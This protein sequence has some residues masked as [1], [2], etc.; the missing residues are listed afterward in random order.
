[1]SIHTS[2]TSLHNMLT[3]S[4]VSSTDATVKLGWMTVATLVEE[5]GEWFVTMPI[6]TRS[7]PI[8]V[9]GDKTM[10]AALERLV[11]YLGD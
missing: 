1:M 5:E 11:K 9:V 4:D 10:E 8:S 2:L 7:M 6:G 3:L